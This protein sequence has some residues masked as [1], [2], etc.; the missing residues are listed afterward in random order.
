[1]SDPEFVKQLDQQRDAF[2]DLQD[3]FGKL[4]QTL[5]MNDEGN[6]R[7]LLSHID[8]TVEQLR[9]DTRTL[10]DKLIANVKKESEESA[11]TSDAMIRNSIIIS[12]V[13]LLG[14]LGLAYA[15]V[16]GGAVGPLTRLAAVM[17]RLAKGDFSVEI[18]GTQRGDEVGMMARCAETFKKSGL[19][20]IALRRQQ[21]EDRLKAEAEAKKAE[22]RRSRGS[23]ASSAA[24]SARR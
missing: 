1:M 18:D 15:V 13:I 21:E 8:T 4:K 6:A 16:Q 17:E 14:A 22:P 19:E 9:S 10:T 23:A 12:V 3:D 11:L 2:S 7:K 5:R 20:A 24:R